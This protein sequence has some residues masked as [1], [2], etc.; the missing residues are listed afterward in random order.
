MDFNQFFR[1]KI[2]KITLLTIGL[3]I[4]ILLI[5]Q[6]GMLVGFKKAGFSYRWGENY[7]RNFAGP[8]GGFFQDFA[9][10]DFIEAHGVFGPIIKIDGSTLVIKGERDIEKIILLKDD[11]VIKHFQDT[12]KP[13]DLKID[14]H[15]IVIGSPNDA[16]QIEAKLI[17]VLPPPSSGMPPP[18]GM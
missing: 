3:L 16:G 6:A 18:P 15:I 9:D 13:G 10:K 11:T 4:I 2:F 14:D 7:H 12:I 8:R 1:S 17:R 5:F